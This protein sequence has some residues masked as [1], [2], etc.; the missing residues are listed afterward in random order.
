MTSMP[1]LSARLGRPLLDQLVEEIAADD[2]TGEAMKLVEEGIARHFEELIALGIVKPHDSLPNRRIN[3]VSEWNAMCG[4][5]GGLWLGQESQRRRIASRILMMLAWHDLHS[6]GWDVRHGKSDP[7]AREQAM[8]RVEA[9]MD[10]GTSDIIWAGEEQDFVSGE[11]LSFMLSG[12]NLVVGRRIRD[13]RSRARDAVLEPIED[14]EPIRLHE[15]EI[16]AP[17]GRLLVAEW[18][19]VPGFTELVDEGDPWRGG[20]DAENESD[21]ERYVRDHG[22][23][24]V[25]TIRR[26]L[27]VFTRGDAIG[28]GHHDEDGDHPKPKGCR[29]VA[30]FMVDLRKVS[31]VDRAVLL[32]IV[33]RIHPD[34][35]AEAM[36][37][38]MEKTRG[39]V[40]LNMRPGRYRVSS[41]GRGHVDDLLP[42]GHRF[43]SQGFQAVVTLE[44]AA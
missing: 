6:I 10:G 44:R 43:A 21:A 26:S 41:S 17:T 42:D 8:R 13:W 23:V 2:R 30:D 19:H 32:D 31:I 22:F 39:V 27:T 28:I 5:G 9:R 40:R 14:L 38:E 33:R 24:S 15:T 12:W 37:A 36:V 3:I 4:T 7:E 16:E 1:S 18:F 34:G 29:R 20:S 25:S 35:D 11:E